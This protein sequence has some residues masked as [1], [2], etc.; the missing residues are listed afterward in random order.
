LGLRRFWSWSSGA[1]KGSRSWRIQ[2]VRLCFPPR[3]ASGSPQPDR[4]T[5]WPT[6]PRP[7][8]QDV[9]QA[10]IGM[11]IESLLLP[12]KEESDD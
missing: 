5:L 3:N 10:L 8:Q 1:D 9:I 4:L 6:I 7:V 12:T 11:L 2:H